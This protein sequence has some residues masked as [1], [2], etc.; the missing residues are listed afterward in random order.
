MVGKIVPPKGLATPF[1]ANKGRVPRGVHVPPGDA[2]THQA[3]PLKFAAQPKIAKIKAPRR[4]G[5]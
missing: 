5:K 4:R 2:D 3:R 1:K